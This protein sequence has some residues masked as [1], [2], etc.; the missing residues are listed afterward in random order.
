[1][2]LTGFCSLPPDVSNIKGLDP[3]CAGKCILLNK[4]LYHIGIMN[5]RKV[6]SAV[7]GRKSYQVITIYNN[8]RCSCIQN[9]LIYIFPDGARVKTETY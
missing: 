5:A 3:R 7:F 9:Y 4:E 1:M 2:F 8:F 6:T